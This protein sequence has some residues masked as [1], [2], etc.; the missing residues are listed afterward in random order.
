MRIVTEILGVPFDVLTMESAIEKAIHFFEDGGRHIICTPNPE[1]VMQAQSD[2]QL[3]N[4]LKAADLVV[5][6]GIG[7]VWASKHS[8]VKINERVAGYDLCQNIM[9]RMAKAGKSAYFFGGAPGVAAAAA[10]KM[11]KEYPGLKVLGTRNGFFNLRDEKEIIAEIKA[12]KPDLLLVG[13]GAPKQEKWI[14]ENL[15]FT[16]AKVAIGVGGSFDV[17]AGNLKRAP[18][19]YQKLGLEWFHRLICQP[20]RIK[21]MMNL[22]LFVLKVIM[23]KK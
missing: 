19:I 16:G 3:M 2:E 11:V 6:D 9:K 4:I 8:S 15:R 10:K 14:Y 17:M 12:L 23:S 13:I 20:T 1:I 7:I 5:P 21:R 18:K 22:P